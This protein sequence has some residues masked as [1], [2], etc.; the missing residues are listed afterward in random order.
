MNG[1]LTYTYGRIKTD[2]IDYPLDHIPPVYGKVSLIYLTKK[3]KSE[4]F[5]LFNGWKKKKDYNMFGE[6]N[7]DYA[8]QYGMPAWYTINIILFYQLNRYIQFNIGMENILDANYR[9]FSSNISA[10]GRNF[11]AGLRITW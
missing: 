6:D 1:S 8:T 2:T 11:K 5:I 7:F 3:L 10:P 9:T 4:F